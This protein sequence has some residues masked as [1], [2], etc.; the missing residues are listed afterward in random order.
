MRGLLLSA[1]FA[2]VFAGLNGCSKKTNELTGDGIVTIGIY[3]DE[4][5][6][7]V[8]YVAAENM[9]SWMGFETRRI[10][11]STLNEGD[12]EHIDVFYFPGGSY[13]SLIDE[14]GR[15][16]LRDAIA[17]GRGCIGTCGGAYFA[18]YLGVFPGTLTGPVP[19]LDLEMCEVYLI[20]PHPITDD[21]PAKLWIMYVNSPYFVPNSDAAIDTIGFYN[22]SGY[23]ALVACEYGTGR[24]F[25]T[26]PHPEW[27]EDDDRDG[28]STYDSFDDVESD[29]PMMYNATRWCLY[30]L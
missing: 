28:I 12:I 14:T 3:A 29:W 5:A 8:C 6:A 4:G 22:V 20:R 25:L 7:A 27:E 18:A 26:G 10:Y 1:L 13:G 9:F 2:F 16:R 19:G 17:S 11:A 24:V 15:Q 30:D 21:Q 23:P